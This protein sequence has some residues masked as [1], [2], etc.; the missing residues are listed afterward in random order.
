MDLFSSLE[1]TPIEVLELPNAAISYHANFLSNKDA[2]YYFEILKDTIAWQQDDI[3]LF[4]KTYAQPRLT[5]LYGEKGKT[6]KYSSITMQMLPFTNEILAVK[7]QVEKITGHSFNSVLLN[8]YRDGNDSNGW[9]S[10][11][12]KSLGKNPVIASVSLGAKRVFQLKHKGDSSLRHNITLHHGSLLLMEGETQ[13]FWK[14]QI[15]KSKKV[16]EKRINLT[17]RVIH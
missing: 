9:H 3:R 7:N 17:F 13:H 1:P 12:E 8:L 6:Y 11:D 4:G 14:H 2:S 16:L 10:D 5:A 15:P